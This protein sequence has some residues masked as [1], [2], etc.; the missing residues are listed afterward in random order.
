MQAAQGIER[1][2]V[3]QSKVF[4][5]A[6]RSNENMLVCAPTGAGKT[7]I[8]LLSILHEVGRNIRGVLKKGACQ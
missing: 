1:L 2:N 7:N 3:I 5:T 4:E 8:A 6:F